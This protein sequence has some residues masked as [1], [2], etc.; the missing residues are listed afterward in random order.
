MNPTYHLHEARRQGVTALEEGFSDGSDDDEDE[1]ASDDDAVIMGGDFLGA[2]SREM[3]EH[4][5]S[6]GAISMSSP[7]PLRSN[8]SLLR[9]SPLR[10]SP[11]L[12][13]SSV[14]SRSRSGSAILSS[15][16]SPSRDHHQHPPIRRSSSARPARSSSKKR[17]RELSGSTSATTR[18]TR[19]ED[20]MGYFQALISRGTRS[21]AVAFED[22]ASVTSGSPVRKKLRREAE[23]EE[24]D[25]GMYRDS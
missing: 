17:A 20:P 23:E 19:S 11:P 25:A 24:E 16:P 15:L 14:I 6:M 5:V 9:S 7:S 3:L 1:E 4:L 21:P 2:P 13:S 18:S 12:R 8:S 10:A 22:E